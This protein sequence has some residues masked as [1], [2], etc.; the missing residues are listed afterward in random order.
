MVLYGIP[1]TVHEK[2]SFFRLKKTKIIYAYIYIYIHTLC[3]EVPTGP[4]DCC[5]PESKFPAFTGPGFG[6]P[7]NSGDKRRR[8]CPPSERPCCRDRKY[9]RQIL[10]SNRDFKSASSRIYAAEG[11]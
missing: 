6:T 11:K 10:T 4:S 3:M 2:L 9:L 7:R 5:R 1:G 8:P